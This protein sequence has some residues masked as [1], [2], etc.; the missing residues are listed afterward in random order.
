METDPGELSVR[1]SIVIK[2][3]PERVWEEF[4]SF[5]RMRRW[6]ST[7]KPDRKETLVRYEPQVGGAMEMEIES[8]GELIRFVC[9]VTAFEPG[10]ELTFELDW[11]ERGWLAPTLVT[12]RLTPNPYGTLVEIVHY[13][14]EGI[15]EEAL[16]QFHGFGGGW[17]LR[18]LEGLKRAVEGA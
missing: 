14:F 8:G 16:D 17:D 1:R 3:P 15:G 12:V 10:R 5:E 13:G 4:T 2:A 6:W 18:E 7:D 9:R 11:P